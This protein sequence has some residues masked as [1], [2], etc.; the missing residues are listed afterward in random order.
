MD[1]RNEPLTTPDG[2]KPKLK[3]NGVDSTVTIE[4][5]ANKDSVGLTILTALIDLIFKKV[6]SGEYSITYIHGAVT[7]F[8]G[9]MVSYSSVQNNNND[10]YAISL[11]LSKAT[12]GTT[13][14]DVAPKEAD[15]ILGT[16]PDAV[17]IA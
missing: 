15:T 14:E 11:E 2:K 1:I 16:T 8:N 10:L 3:Q 12:G 17:G 13:V 5:L 7:V 6:T 4:M 9:V